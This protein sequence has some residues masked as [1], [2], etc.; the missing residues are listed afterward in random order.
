MI[1]VYRAECGWCS[2]RSGNVSTVEQVER[3][4]VEHFQEQHPD[5]LAA[6]AYPSRT[7]SPQPRALAKC[8]LLEAKR[9]GPIGKAAEIGSE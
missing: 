9:K 4:L 7:S 3:L 2:M 5:R 8:P 1:H 6:L